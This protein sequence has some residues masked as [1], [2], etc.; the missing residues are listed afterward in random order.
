MLGISTTALISHTAIY[1]A[2][3]SCGIIQLRRDGVLL[4]KLILSV[5]GLGGTQDPRTQVEAVGLLQV[6]IEPVEPNAVYVGHVHGSAVG[7]VC[8][9]G[10]GDE[11]YGDTIVLESVV[12]RVSVG[13]WDAAIAGVVEDQRRRS[14]SA[15][16]SDGRLFLVGF[17]VL[18][19]PR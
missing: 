7:K 10:N 3:M 14:D 15:R 12:Q 1:L 11:F 6:L 18:F 4:R 9:H 17:R 19:L 13:D 2:Q 8:I 16:I 5:C